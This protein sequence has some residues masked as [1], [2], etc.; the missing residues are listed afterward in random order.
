MERKRYLPTDF[1]SYS[2]ASPR[3]APCAFRAP[4]RSCLPPVLVLILS[5]GLLLGCQQNDRLEEQKTRTLT[6]DE[7]YLVEL[8]MKITEFEENL[9]DNPERADEKREELREEIDLERIKRVL[10]ELEQNPQRW[11]AV[12]NRIHE[13]K[14]RRAP[15]SPN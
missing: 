5:A 7:R 11:L 4:P 8:Y 1:H 9:Q 12:Y 2:N 13:L 10:D 15:D 3:R 6:P 14:R